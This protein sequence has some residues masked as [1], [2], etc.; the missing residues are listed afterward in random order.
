MHQLSTHILNAY[1]LNQFLVVVEYY[2]QLKMEICDI[3]N[4]KVLESV[5]DSYIKLCKFKTALKLLNAVVKNKDLHLHFRALEKA[6]DYLFLSLASALSSRKLYFSEYFIL[7]WYKQLRG[8]NKKLLSYLEQI[9]QILLIRY[10]VWNNRFNYLFALLIV[11]NMSLRILWEISIN[12]VL[13]IWLLIIGLSWIVLNRVLPVR[14]KI[15][16]FRNIVLIT[17]GFLKDE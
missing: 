17:N 6:V 9:E 16:G 7:L 11:M 10:N 2:E 3:Q 12:P 8:K 13:M 4:E 14:H 15:I 5:V 1:R